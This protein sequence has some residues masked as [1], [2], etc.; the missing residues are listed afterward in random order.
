MA[1]IKHRLVCFDSHEE[2]ALKKFKAIE[3]QDQDQDDTKQAAPAE[4]LHIPRPFHSYFGAIP[5]F[6]VYKSIILGDKLCVVGRWNSEICLQFISLH[7]GTL[8][9][10]ATIT[11]FKT[12]IMTE[13][14]CQVDMVVAVTMDEPTAHSVLVLTVNPFQISYKAIRS[15][16]FIYPYLLREEDIDSTYEAR[17]MQSQHG[18]LLVSCSR[19]VKCVSITDAHSLMVDP[20]QPT[21]F[22]TTTH[23][24]VL[25]INTKGQVMLRFKIPSALL[26]RANVGIFLDADILYLFHRGQPFFTSMN[27]KTGQIIQLAISFQMPSAHLLPPKMEVK[28]PFIWSIGPSFEVDHVLVS[29]LDHLFDLD[30]NTGQMTWI[31]SS[32]R[33]EDAFFHAFVSSTIC[34]M[35]S[36]F[37]SPLKQIWCTVQNEMLEHVQVFQI[38]M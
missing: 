29:D 16:Y 17:R 23:T 21:S 35:S 18:V 20:S 38:Q 15:L 32:T 24:H 25:K 7:T 12:G 36:C 34:A 31:T 28:F 22:F 6:L 2:P 1:S 37:C 26:P 5:G 10:P 30:L 19:S 8:D 13:L 3:Y 27:K 4:D 33:K 9:Q 14:S 11:L